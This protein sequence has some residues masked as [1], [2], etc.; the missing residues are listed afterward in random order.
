V[1]IQKTTIFRGSSKSIGTVGF[2]SKKN[3]KFKI[4]TKERIAKGYY[5][6]GI[7][8]WGSS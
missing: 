8:N 5:K 3:E 4:E 6:S 1:L 7:V 2:T